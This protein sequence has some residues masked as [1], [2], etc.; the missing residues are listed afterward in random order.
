MAYFTIKSRKFV[1]RIRKPILGEAYDFDLTRW[2]LTACSHSVMNVVNQKSLW[3]SGPSLTR[4]HYLHLIRGMTRSYRKP[5]RLV[6]EPAARLVCESTF[7]HTPPIVAQEHVGPLVSGAIYAIASVCKAS[8][9]HGGRTMGL[10]TSSPTAPGEN[11][12]EFIYSYNASSVS[13]N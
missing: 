5:S 6:F 13:Q 1:F 11:G 7:N 8:A 9:R 10:E 2:T 12:G 3:N 4:S